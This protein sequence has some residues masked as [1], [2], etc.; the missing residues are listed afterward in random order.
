MKIQQENNVKKGSI[1]YILLLLLQRFIGIGLF[2]AF[3]GT[4]YDIRGNV[5]MALYFTVS[6]VACIVMFYGHKETLYERGKK[7]NNTKNWDK[8]LLPIYILLAYFGIYLVAGLG[9]RLHW[10]KLPIECFYVG[11]ILYLFSSVFVIWPVLENK[12]FEATSRIQ[13]NR[14]QTVIKTGPYKIVRHPGYAGIVIW[15]IAFFL[16]FGTLAVGI[17]SLIIIV[18]ILIRTYLEDKML[19]NELEGYLDYSKN[20][21]YR[22]IP[23][24]W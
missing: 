5:N 8:I 3:A 12:H 18:T 1:K 21:K 13:D 23:F 24:I 6:I 14:E 16:M 2:F 4:F 9:I 19:K 20:T 17:V 11:I 22:L 7:Q 15:V 10:E